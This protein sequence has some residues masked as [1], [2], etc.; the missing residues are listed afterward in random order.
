[1]EREVEGVMIGVVILV[2]IS[3]IFAMIGQIHQNVYATPWFL[4]LDLELRFFLL[5]L[6][7]LLVVRR[8]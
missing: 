6:D 5:L 7:S 8:S 3:F 2:F 4:F 1:L